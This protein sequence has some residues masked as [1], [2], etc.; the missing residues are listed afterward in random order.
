VPSFGR[1]SVGA[2]GDVGLQVFQRLLLVTVM[3]GGLHPA[4]ALPLC[5]GLQAATEELKI[6]PMRNSLIE[7]IAT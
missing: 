5:L 7:N 3:S 2:S 1:S 6:K 4:H